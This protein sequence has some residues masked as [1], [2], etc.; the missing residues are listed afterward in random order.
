MSRTS[1]LNVMGGKKKSASGLMRTTLN[2]SS[3]YPGQQRFVCKVESSPMIYTTT[4]TSGII[5]DQYQVDPVNQVTGWSS[6][7]GAC[8]DEFRV[9]KAVFRL[10]PLVAST[11]LT[12]FWI[13]EKNA[14][15]GTA[16]EAKERN[17]L[18]LLNTN[19]A[20]SANAQLVWKA[21]DLLDL[22]YTATQTSVV[23]AQLKIYTSNAAWGSTAVATP[24]WIIEAQYDIEF[25]GIKST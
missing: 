16:N 4:V 25:R 12:R 17:G 5:S 13:D 7:F 24:L 18:Y 20:P 8:F 11:G 1:K 15:A 3:S 19:A 22:Q 23:P 21:K 2:D 6:R 14:G 9:L 10:R